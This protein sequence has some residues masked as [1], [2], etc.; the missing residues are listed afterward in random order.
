MRTLRSGGQNAAFSLF[1]FQDILT[2][3]IGVV[4]L[5]M[6]LLVLEISKDAA[7]AK[8]IPQ[9]E[10]QQ[11]SIH[12]LE[13]IVATS[14]QAVSILK[15]NSANE[16]IAFIQSQIKE[17][18]EQTKQ[19]TQ[20]VIDIVAKASIDPNP[21]IVNELYKQIEVISKNIE[22]LEEQITDALD[23]S[24]AAAELAT[25]RNTKE[26]LEHQLRGLLA[27]DSLVYIKQDDP[28]HTPFLVEVGVDY[29][30]IHGHGVAQGLVDVRL[31]EVDEATRI[32]SAVSIIEQ[33]VTNRY[34]PLILVRRG[35]GSSSE[36]I[37]FYLKNQGIASGID[38]LVGDQTSIPEHIVSGDLSP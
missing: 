28:S 22:E 18:Q 24:E 6:L 26:K 9:V 13:Q 35:G 17:E 10:Q 27:N 37:R 12:E 36:I 5:I 25:L 21:D 30:C 4:L 14:V 29:I 7:T 19:I 2:T 3:T 20:G 23:N 32:K 33:L 16:A 11:I 15:N 34:Y 8:V 31:Y 38:L 1:A